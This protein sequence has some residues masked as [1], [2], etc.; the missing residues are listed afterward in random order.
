MIIGIQLLPGVSPFPIGTSI[1]P[2]AFILC[3]GAIKDGIEDYDRHKSDKIA[4]SLPILRLNP[5]TGQFK[6]TLSANLQPSDIIILK[7]HQR[8]PADCIVLGCDNSNGD[9]S[10]VCYINTSSMDGENAP[11]LRRAVRPTVNITNPADLGKLEGYIKCP[12]NTKSLHGFTGALS[13]KKSSFPQSTN[14]LSPSNT[15]NNGINAK[16][17]KKNNEKSKLNTSMNDKSTNYGTMTEDEDEEDGDDEH[18]VANGSKNKDNNNLSPSQPSLGLSSSNSNNNAKAQAIAAMQGDKISGLSDMNFVFRGSKL[19]NTEYIYALVLFVGRETKLMLNRNQVPFKF[20]K[21]EKIL[22][23]MILS[24]L[25]FNFILCIAFGIAANV[26][27]E[28]YPELVRKSWITSFLLD[29]CSWLIVT[30]WMIPFSLYVTLE[31]VKMIQAQWVAWDDK[32]T[33]DPDPSSISTTE[34]KA[35]DTS[36]DIGSRA[37][38]L[39]VDSMDSNNK[40]KGGNKSKSVLS[41]NPYEIDDDGPITDHSW[42]DEFGGKTRH[43]KTK[44]SNLNEEL[45]HIDYVFTDKTG[46]L[47]Q[48]LMELSKCSVG[49]KKFQNDH[50]NEVIAGDFTQFSQLITR[51]VAYQDRKKESYKIHSM[52]HA[53]VNNNNNNLIN[54]INNDLNEQ[55]QRES[56]E[57]LGEI[58]QSS[59]NNK[60]NEKKV[61]KHADTL[62]QLQHETHFLFNLLLCSSTLPSRKATKE[63]NNHSS[64]STKALITTANPG[65]NNANDTNNNS[66]RKI[67]KLP[68]TS[69]TNYLNNNY[70]KL[71]NQSLVASTSQDDL[72]EDEEVKRDDTD[73]TDLTE[74]IEAET[75]NKDDTRKHIEFQSPSPDEVAFAEALCDHGI[76]LEERQ[77]DGTIIVRLLNE[78]NTNN[79]DKKKF[80]SIKLKF[81]ILATLDFNARRKRMTV[82]VED[83]LGEIHLYC[84]GADST[85]FRLCNEES[86]I[87]IHETRRHV[88]SFARGGS[89]TLV[90]GWKKLSSEEYDEFDR[91]YREAE[92]ALNNRQT[93]IENAFSYLEH[94]LYLLG[95]TAVEDQMQEGVPEAIYKLKDA[96]IKVIMLTGLFFVYFG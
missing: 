5:S 79:K 38:S 12:P 82:I 35:G 51:C 27:I 84:K 81:K 8:V 54:S 86:K 87:L 56:H 90:M 11:K 22:N 95:C 37:T 45:G 72:N 80:K 30:S 31:L 53:Q 89:R 60:N 55:F 43:A 96:K 19:V 57:L 13:I 28:P 66:G 20:S 76:I 91:Y 40:E 3:V 39:S 85:L 58:Q 73:Q 18:L 26:V 33:Y 70:P 4:N 48:N 49:G 42:D 15:A 68:S 64:A 14:L 2:L 34:V 47:T 36:P 92:V 93:L 63:K 88:T 71:A 78:M 29:T 25:I 7:R 44:N 83:E 41:Q 1:M 46:T 75:K 50:H 52:K 24:I 59:K 6:R 32:M 74:I 77:A 62:S 65:M 61:F 94:S 9:N 67:I 10:G 21:F 16:N 23:Q 69:N 17:G